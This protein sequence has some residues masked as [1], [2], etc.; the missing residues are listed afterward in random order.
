[1]RGLIAASA[2][3]HF[4]ATDAE[5]C[6]LSDA[7]H[8]GW[9]LIV[10]QVRNWKNEVPV[11]E[12]DHELLICK[13]GLFKGFSL[14]WSIVEKEAYSLVKACTDLE[15]LLQREKGFR[16]YTDH[17]NLMYIFNP[18]MEINRHV[19]DKLQPWAMRL[20]GLRYTIKHIDGSSNVSADMI[21][22]WGQPGAESGEAR[23][24]AVRTRRGSAVS[25][26]RPLSDP[27][28]KWPQ[29]D[30]I[31]KCQRKHVKVLRDMVHEVVDGV[32]MVEGRVWVPDNAHE[33]IVCLMVIAHRGSHGHRGEALMTTL[34][35]ERF[36]IH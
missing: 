31:V 9:G 10:S 21:S 32:I 29:R 28:F 36:A 13:G 3:Q 7:S 35:S 17:A 6:V 33:L 12:Q 23:C 2:P 4:S 14:N 25:A 16:M 26:I 11:H 19:R 22:R 24:L 27:G 1:M 30:E 8:G 18:A 20:W 34:L 5:I 15:Y